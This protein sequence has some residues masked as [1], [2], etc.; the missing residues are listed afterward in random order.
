M[1]EYNLRPGQ[2]GFSAGEAFLLKRKAAGTG[3]VS[4]NVKG[5]TAG[6][7]IITNTP[8]GTDACITGD[9]SGREEEM[10]LLEEAF[11]GLGQTLLAAASAGSEENAKIYE[12]QKML[13]DDRDF[14][15]EAKERV[16]SGEFSAAEAVRLTGEQIAARFDASENVYIRQRSAD[17]RGLTGRL[18]ELL[19][20][21]KE[22]NCP[23]RPS[24]IVAEELSPAELSSIDGR[25]ILGI[26]T[27]DGAPTTHVSILAGNLGVPYL[28]GS[29]EAVDAIREGDRLI[30]DGGRLV[31]DPDEEVYRS[32]LLKAD[33]LRKRRQS[34]ADAAAKEKIGTGIF[35]NISGPQDIEALLASGAEGVGLFRSEFLF[36][37][38]E[39][40][41]SEEEQFLAY[42]SV[43]EAMGQKETVI[44]TMDIGS[45]K[46]A[47]WLQLPAEKN[48]QLGMRG[49]R[50]SLKE[51][52]L[53]RTQLRALL[54]AAAY[55]NIKIMLPMITS[56]WEVEA[57]REQME[58]CAKQLEEEG[59]ACRIPPLGIMIETP[60]AV[61]IA[62]ELAEI[63]DFFSI[64]TN[65]LTQ[66]TLALDREGQSLE[67]FY[68]PLHEA[69]FRMIAAAAAAGRRKK[70]PV[71]VCGELAGNEEAV[72]KLIEAGVTAL[73]V[74]VS[75]I[76]RTRAAAFAAEKKREKE[77]LS[78]ELAKQAGL[79]ASLSDN[80][81]GQDDSGSAVN[82]NPDAPGQGYAFCSPADGRVVPM[83]EIPDEAFSGGSLGQCL[84][85]LPENGTV[86]SPCDGIVTSVAGTKHAMT[87][88]TA[89]GTELLLHAGINTVTLG[90]RGFTLLVRSGDTVSAGQEVMKM[91]L[92]LIRGSGLSPMIIIV[93]LKSVN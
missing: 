7:G 44:R 88:R 80:S 13:L 2:P 61:M 55:G 25:L 39:T 62:D 26:I 72:Q 90:G 50:V 5:T 4:G 71:A 10:K 66:Y 78:G 76:G 77:A 68:N 38:R 33:A 49:L 79:S 16:L 57:V 89:E 86:C 17:V 84:G 67:R 18:L 14:Q 22:R 45:D 40:E 48:P 21:Q 27:R 19:S 20:G 87:F 85:I 47:A 58:I 63:S 70:I 11:S 35:A 6:T 65:D 3:K 81:G 15:G 23:E 56:C 36:L 9:H 75:K 73:S 34:E 29:G 37:N 12:A 46:S 93:K 54:R 8:G 32:A 51:E 41:P 92:D 82:A 43:A 28:Y 69:V 83:K 52:R 24:V 59:T 64:G 31:L 30:L 91:D 53:L 1:K 60:A 74:S 42:R